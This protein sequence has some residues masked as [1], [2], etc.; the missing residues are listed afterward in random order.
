[1]IT[2]CKIR[3][4]PF[5]FHFR[6]LLTKSFILAEIKKIM[7]RFGFILLLINFLSSLRTGKTQIGGWN[8]SRPN[9]PGISISL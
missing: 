6:S 7:N 3:N 4:K 5:I 9:A 1:M 8:S 2:E